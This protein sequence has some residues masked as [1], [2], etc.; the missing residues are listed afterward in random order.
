MVTKFEIEPPICIPAIHDAYY[1]AL[2]QLVDYVDKEIVANGE[3]SM[4]KDIQDSCASALVPPTQHASL[5]LLKFLHAHSTAKNDTEE[6]VAAEELKKEILAVCKE[7]KSMLDTQKR[8]AI[9][10]MGSGLVPKN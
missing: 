9:Q 4:P 2:Q 10:M 5:V 8:F 6:I 1:A 3:G 7:L